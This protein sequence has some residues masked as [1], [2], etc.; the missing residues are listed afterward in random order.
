MAR[1]LLAERVPSLEA[2]LAEERAK[3]AALSARVDELLRLGA[4]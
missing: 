2:Q 1:R 4:S 3:V